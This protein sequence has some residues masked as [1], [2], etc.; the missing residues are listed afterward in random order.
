[1]KRIYR[2][3]LVLYPAAFRRRY[4]RELLEAFDEE[5]RDPGY[6]GLRGAAA[7]WRHLVVDL[8]C[9]AARQRRAQ[10][11]RL[12]SGQAP[13]LPPDSRR[14]E[15]D[16]IRQDIGYA[17]RQF[18]RQPGFTA[19]AVLSLALGIGGSTLIYGL[20]DGIVL[21]PFPYPVPDTLV[22]IGATF[23]RVSS[24]T[25][26]VE[27]L[28]PAEYAD[29][30]GARA[31]SSIAAFDL[32]NRNL[33][34]GD[35][36]ERAFT[37]LLLDDP[38]PVLGLEP[39]LGR[40]FTPQE[41]RAS[42]AM[43][44]NTNTFGAAPGISVAII[45]HRLWQ[46]HFGADPN[47]LNRAVRIGGNTASIVG[48]MPAGLL[49]VGTDLWIPW[50]GDP[51][52]VPRDVRQFT[53]IA[54]LARG[55]SLSEANAELKVTAAQIDS[56]QRQA[57]KEYEG[58]RV[59]VT[60]WAAALMQ[61]VRPAG[62]ILLGAV[63]FVLIIAC[64]NLASLFLARATTR[65]RELAVRLALGAG[66][67]RIA[68]LLLTET[69]LLSAA[70]AGAGLLLVHFGL[71]GATALLP[72]Q[73][74]LLGV[75]P[76]LNARVLACAILLALVAGVLV[77]LLPA[78]Q[79]AGTDPHESLKADARAGGARSARR[80]RQA[81]VVG[82]LA[83]S[84][85][86]LLA[87]GLLMRSFLKLQ[88]VDP[89]FDSTGVLTMRLTLPPEKYRSGEEMT[90]FFE[91]LIERIEALPGV[92]AVAFASQFPPSEPFASQVEVEGLS[93]S[94]EQLP[95]TNVTVASK[96]LF[97]TLGIPVLAGQAFTGRERA[98]GVRQVVINDA[99]ASRYLRDRNPIGARVRLAGRGGPGPWAEVIGVVGTSRNAGLDAP[100]RPEAFIA[101]EQGRDA[102]NQLF[103]L[104]RSSTAGHSML[105]AIR[106]AIASL[107]PEQPVYM[108]QTLD[109]ALAAS[110]FQKQASTILIGILAAVALVLAAVGI[111]GVTSY[112]V[113]SRIQ[114]MGVRLAVGAQRRD[115]M[116]LVIGEVLRL[117]GLGLAIGIALLLAAS[118][119]LARLLYGIS[120]ADPLTIAIAAA[121]LGG[122]ALLAAWGPARRASRVDPIE[123]LRYE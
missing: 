116:W 51:A 4:A 17:V 92:S 31:F 94:G 26:Y 5:R 30:R 53:V 34:G 78:V 123:A 72:A 107:D 120:A 68:R 75:S 108:I 102:W 32:G 29:L 98:A 27:A 49:L 110:S 56:A 46:T 33:A 111:Y 43:R 61:D 39:A 79:A 119:S 66:G 16:T 3:L 115:V 82:E 10:V 71:Q 88:H 100:G 95:T 11:A 12:P 93:G 96:N 23:P 57:F 15:M 44:G 38:F 55:V 41:L 99:F 121:M 76:A 6:A 62:F 97:R 81:L 63:A 54:R 74:A 22:T 52:Q 117:A 67:W 73:L 122:V 37:A 13:A 91:R 77:G 87:A 47:I 83:L 104:V 114:E 7:L 59:T 105:P 90:T 19:I 48:V 69:L 20:V 106:Q 9:T 60:P 86:L 14:S 101:M 50:G 36:P 118:R 65:Q 70:G 58:W 85:T 89:G 35:V 113:T 2:A 8:L 112:A 64:A 28:S 42:T 25:A 109:E 21:S 40:G 24:E 80:L 1:M 18:A 103:L 45:S 84:V